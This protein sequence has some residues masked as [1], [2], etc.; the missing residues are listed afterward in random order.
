MP[1]FTPKPP[2]FNVGDLIRAEDASNANT[3]YRVVAVKPAKNPPEWTQREIT[4]RPMF[5]LFKSDYKLNKK[6]GEGYDYVKVDLLDLGYARN[7][8]DLFMREEVRRLSGEENGAHDR[9]QE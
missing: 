7:R 2:A 3:L 6:I 5:G 9:P 1:K 8:L 4:M